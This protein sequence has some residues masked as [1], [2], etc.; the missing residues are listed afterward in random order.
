[1]N[2]LMQRI[3]H[4]VASPIGAALLLALLLPLR[5]AAQNY[6]NNP[7]PPCDTNDPASP[8]YKPPEPPPKC[9]PI[10]CDKCTKSPCFVGSGVFINDAQDLEIATAGFPIAI[11]RHYQSTHTID[12]ESGYGWTSSL[13]TRLYYA[14]FLKS[15]PSTY[16]R[17]ADIR[18]PNGAVYRFVENADGSFTPPDGR[19]DTL[20]RN[21]DSTWDLWLQHS[22]S[23]YH[24]SATGNLLEMVDDYGN[25]QSWTYASDRLQRVA[26]SSGSARYVDITY[27]ADG[28]ISDVTDHTGRNVHYTYDSRGVMTAARN[29][30][31]QSTA[32]SY[33]NGKYVPLLSAVTDP[34]GRNVTTVTYD[35]QD[36]TRSYTDK[37]ETYTYTYNYNGVATT[38]GKSDSGGNVW[39]YPFGS[40]GL[41]SD[42]QPP[43]GGPAEHNDYYSN[44]LLQ[45]QTDALGIKT[46]YTYTAT[47]ELLTVTND[48]LGA[49]AVEWRYAYD[50]NFPDRVVSVTPYDPAT[51]AINHNWQ[52][53]KYDYYGPG[54]PSPG[55]LHHEYNVHDDG[56]TADVL[57]TYTYDTHGRVL[58]DTDSNGSTTTCTYDAY[59]NLATLDRP[60]NDDAASARLTTLSYD[61]L[62]RRTAVTDAE[63]H[64][65]TFTYDVL[66]RLTSRTLPAPST[67]S[68][69]TFTLTFHYDEFDSASQL[70][71]HRT[72]DAN[73]ATTKVGIDAFD[74]VNQSIDEMG[75]AT[76]FSFV[77]G[78]LASRSDANNNVT[79]FSYD[80]RHRLTRTTYPD[81]TFEQYTYAA[82][83]AVATRRSRAGVVT[84]LGYDRQKRLL[85]ITSPAG[86]ITGTFA[87]DKLTQITDTTVSPSETFTQTWTDD[88]RA[89]TIAEG[90]R[91]TVSYT[92]RTDG[93]V[94]TRTR[95]GGAT[96]TYGY[97]PDGS[98]RT[99]TWGPAAGDFKYDYTRN[100][101]T[102]A[103]T[104]P[105]GQTRSFQYDD[106]GRL[107]QIANTH[108]TAG[109]VAT[110][111]YGYD[112]DP[113]TSQAIRLGL[114]T[115]SVADVPALG[116]T[117]ALTKY[118][119]DNHYRL[120]TV[121]YPGAAPYSGAV[122]S[123]TYDAIGNRTSATTN[124]A[125]T[126]YTYAKYNANTLNS[127]LLV[128]D[129][130]NNY[131]YD[132]NG[133]MTGRTGSAGA[134]TFTYDSENRLRTVAGAESASYAYDYHGR[135]TVTTV[136][137]ASTSHLY[138]GLERIADIGASPAEYLFGPGLDEPL[139]MARGGQ[140]YYYDTDGLGSVVTVN[141][142]AGTVQRSYA[143]DA[144]GS[145]LASNGTLANPFGYTSREF[146]EAGLDHYR[147]RT[148]QPS[149]GAFRSVDPLVRIK[150]ETYASGRRPEVPPDYAYAEDSPTQFTDPLGLDAA[151]CSSCEKGLRLAIFDCLTEF[152]GLQLTCQLAFSICLLATKRLTCLYQLAACESFAA[153]RWH[154]CRAIAYRNYND[155]IK[156]CKCP[157]PPP[158]P[159]TQR[160]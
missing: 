104:F 105:N 6:C 157:P 141:D 72:V 3:R 125:T 4:T 130:T 35:A 5:A 160:A 16:A 75:G 73:G 62:G 1:M 69:L 15:A 137:G 83:D 133:N 100:G 57:H 42:S 11:T 20:V 23:R 29:P 148:Y 153:Y 94:A 147:F 92:Y 24:F 54:S 50:A 74:Q 101:R 140:I 86:T 19:F 122:S 45:I 123:W 55:A 99:L 87:G 119:Y 142:A 118:G 111:A 48:Y 82:N 64:V 98:V 127:S 93:H 31:A 146:G 49:T 36:R 97:Y 143:Y 109:N 85:T 26:D 14:V 63:G 134:Y 121:A 149:I 71:F 67:G 102:Q 91:G 96:T 154:R 78:L 40:G 37:G 114:R 30:A 152:T 103:I 151:P 34:W 65:T 132:A 2:R 12:G 25:T 43:G 115:T 10:V 21:N 159:E 39:V 144:W 7:I 70:L 79:T 150:Q 80:G 89:S 76:R 124:G 59:G 136:G 52:G 108:P 46:R 106:Q 139:A 113:F 88:F 13:S 53:Q 107:L 60:A 128:S 131:T 22:R 90:S 126:G 47:G 84:T 38:T 135:R 58:T 156:G 158:P 33:V 129:G 8:C 56:V 116:L 28:R 81:G 120:T 17:E 117:A 155:C 27:G 32:Y 51:N 145:V 95:T 110:F 18:L 138:S 9:E 66:D 112:V 77:K 44:G 68:P 61:N 41:V